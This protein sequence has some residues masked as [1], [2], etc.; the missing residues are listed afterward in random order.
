MQVR[1]TMD[2]SKEA[3]FNILQSRHNLHGLKILD[4][5]AGFGGISLE[6]IS[7]GASEVTMVEKMGPN[8]AFIKE[9]LEKMG[10]THRA[11]IIKMSAEVYVSSCK[12]QFDFI[13]M[14]PPYAWP[15]YRPLIRAI[16]GRNLLVADGLLV[17]EHETQ[18]HFDEEEG[19]LETRKYGGSSFSFFEPLNGAQEKID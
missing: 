7:R 17:V 1:P 11:T 19:W 10:E 5:F 4:L 8:I 14:D 18:L 2:L 16:L 13:F 15:G 12:Q 6:F 9:T 3:L